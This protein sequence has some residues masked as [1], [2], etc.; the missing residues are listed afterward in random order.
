MSVIP[1]FLLAAGAAAAELQLQVPGQARALRFE[2]PEGAR[3]N[4]ISPRMAQAAG[5]DVRF[6][7]VLKREESAKSALDCRRL[8]SSFQRMTPQKN[9]PPE[10]GRLP[11]ITEGGDEERPTLEYSSRNARSRRLY[12]WENGFCAEL[13]VA[14]DSYTDEREPLLSITARF[15]VPLPLS[16]SRQALSAGQRLL[17]RKQY[18]EAL[19]AYK[20]A[21]SHPDQLH[22]SEIVTAYEGLGVTALEL[23]EAETAV[24]AL[25]KAGELRAR[26]REEMSR[27]RRF[28]LARAFALW[29]RLDEAETA[30]RLLLESAAEFDYLDYERFKQRAYEDSKL[31]ALR[32]RTSF[33]KI[34]ELPKP[35]T[36]EG[37]RR[38]ADGLMKQGSYREAMAVYQEIIS[39]PKG[40]D[41]FWLRLAYRGLGLSA[42]AVDDAAAVPALQ[43]AA[44]LGHYGQQVDVLLDL[45]RAHAMLG[46]LDLAEAALRYGL[47]RSVAD[48]G[49]DPRRFFDSAR[50]EVKLAALRARPSV[51]EFMGAEP[52]KTHAD[53]RLKEAEK[54]LADRLHGRAF[55]VYWDLLSSPETLDKKQQADAFYGLGKAA[56]AFDDVKS[57]AAAM[58]AASERL[59]PSTDSALQFDLACAHALLGALD[60]A[61]QSLRA[62]LRALS[63]GGVASAPYDEY[64]QRARSDSR[65]AALRE[66]ASFSVLFDAISP[67]EHQA[68]LKLAKL[69]SLTKIQKH[70]EAFQGYKEI[71]SKP[72]GLS[73][74][75]RAYARHGLGKTALELGDAKTAAAALEEVAELLR[76]RRLALPDGRPADARDERVLDA[77]Y[78]L[79]CAYAMLGRFDRAD[80]LLRSTLELA[81]EYGDG[82]RSVYYNAY[83]DFAR[84]DSKAAALRKL[85]SF[86]EVA[87]LSGLDKLYEAVNLIEKKKYAEAAPMFKEVIAEPEFGDEGEEEYSNEHVAMAYGGLGIALL[88]RGDA[89][90]AASLLEK[91]DRL[92]PREPQIK[93][94][95]AGAYAALGRLDLAETALRSSLVGAFTDESEYERLAKVARTDLKFAV[96]R[97]RPSFATVFDPPANKDKLREAASAQYAEAASIYREIFANPEGLDEDELVGAY[98][99]YGKKALD[100]GDARAAE[101]ALMQAFLQA[102]PDPEILFDLAC[103]YSMLGDLDSAE[104][105]LRMC[106]VVEPELQKRYI[107]K[108]RSDPK[109]KALRESPSFPKILEPRTRMGRG[110]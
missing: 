87:P 92:S 62:G 10:A 71:L 25:K 89:A 14:L 56:L 55:A 31:A 65:L 4:I 68:R 28:D 73:L 42:L 20:Q 52:T 51:A 97:A 12:L 16:P 58:E 27:E 35:S 90:E 36:S 26:R 18:P 106:L 43:T 3:L 17:F 61:E 49:G 1:L 99:D 98:R 94:E 38:Y 39:N 23:S 34:I 82:R 63:P 5:E 102:G 2:L 46:Q 109:L 57:A 67:A 29:G 108:A 105:N 79:A 100:A 13:L 85:P 9:R 80:A 88:A 104:K 19:A 83:V 91:A 41:K 7:A 50:G 8:S 95:L 21:V 74:E 22:D 30:L 54:L 78:H 37:R 60:R 75:V 81:L 110:N 93:F 66:R 59:L 103:A 11:I 96:L 70:A 86:D 47:V 107:D 32:K 6:S 53:N 15:D 24:S 69:Y 44:E 101:A 48:S 76:R 40:L 84:N 45:A 33:I 77:Q 72:E 64:A